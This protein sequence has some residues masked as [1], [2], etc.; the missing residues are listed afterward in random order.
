MPATTTTGAPKYTPLYTRAQAVE[1]VWQ[2]SKTIRDCYKN[3]LEFDLDD[4]T[5]SEYNT[6]GHTAPGETISEIIHNGIED[7]LIV[8]ECGN[9]RVI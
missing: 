8:E 4:Y 5:R 7:S 3:E 9:Y 2:K 1:Y 6:Y